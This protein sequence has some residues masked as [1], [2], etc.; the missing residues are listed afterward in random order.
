[1]FL[2][3]CLSRLSVSIF[4]M[5]IVCTL[6]TWLCACV[7]THTQVILVTYGNYSHKDTSDTDGYF[8]ILRLF[9]FS[10]V[11]NL[12]FWRSFRFTENW[13]DNTET[14]YIPSF[15]LFLLNLPYYQYLAFGWNFFFFLQLM[16]QYWCIV[17]TK[18]HSLWFT[19]LSMGPVGLD[20]YTYNIMYL[21][22]QYHI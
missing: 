8:W 20:I 15:S 22:L 5:F 4:C 12:N 9:F 7:H 16:S 21:S 14:S 10:K 6:C 19:P 2:F 11:F 17:L 18:V 1:M 13:V 3:I